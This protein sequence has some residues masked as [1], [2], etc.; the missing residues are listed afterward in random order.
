[1]SVPGHLWGNQSCLILAVCSRLSIVAGEATE[2]GRSRQASQLISVCSPPKSEQASSIAAR[3]SPG[4][5]P[6]LRE[7]RRIARRCRRRNRPWP[8]GSGAPGQ[9]P[10]LGCV[11]SI[12]AATPRAGSSNRVILRRRGHNRAE[13]STDDRNRILIEG[14]AAGLWPVWG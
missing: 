4:R 14:I 3:S 11:G 12:A 1:M 5:L 6:H 2:P 9:V 10:I 13:S 8:V 7:N